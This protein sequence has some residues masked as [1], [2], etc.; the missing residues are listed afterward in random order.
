MWTLSNTAVWIHWRDLSKGVTDT[1][2]I[3]YLH[4]LNVYSSN[5]M[6]N[7]TKGQEGKFSQIKKKF[8]FLRS[9]AEYMIYIW[10]VPISSLETFCDDSYPNFLV[11]V[12][13]SF[14]ISQ[15]CKQT[16]MTG[17]FLAEGLILVIPSEGK[18]NQ[19]VHLYGYFFYVCF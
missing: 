8:C 2:I 17:T 9:I 7:G 1:Y 14:P 3:S 19:P 15:R 11:S 16:S 12:A 13:L 6:E 5:S 10:T 4:F 18:N